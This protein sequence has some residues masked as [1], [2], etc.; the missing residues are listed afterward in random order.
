MLLLLIK[1]I[2]NKYNNIK[3]IKNNYQQH[4]LDTYFGLFY[5]QNL[6]NLSN[7]SISEHSIF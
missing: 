1:K 6:L 3:F 2:V 5:K 7:L 4:F